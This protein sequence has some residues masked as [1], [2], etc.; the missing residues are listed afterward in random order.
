VPTHTIA[1]SV[2]NANGGTPISAVYSP[3]APNEWTYDATL[4]NATDVTVTQAMTVANLESLVITA[5]QDMTVRVNGVNEVQTV[6]FTGTVS[7]GTF[8]LTYSG[9]TTAAIAWNASA[10]TVKTALEDL[11][12]IGVDDVSVS[13][14]GSFGT[15]AVYTVTFRKALAAT[16]VAQMTSSAASLTGSTPGITHATTTAGVAAGQTITV[17]ANAPAP[18]YIQDLGWTNPYT[19]N[20]TTLLISNDSG[21]PGTVSLRA[22]YN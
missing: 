8:T 2:A 17:K 9:Q 21:A 5:T 15:G 4:N 19:T 12:N 10:A 7:G 22:L 11:S 14:N 6:T 13:H 3:T 1:I 18:V 20:W 16:N